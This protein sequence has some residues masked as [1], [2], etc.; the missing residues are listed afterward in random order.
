MVYDFI[1]VSKIVDFR[2][3]VGY[4][5]MLSMTSDYIINPWFIYLLGLIPH[6]SA[7]CLMITFTLFTLGVIHHIEGRGPFDVI[8]DFI[9]K[10][11]CIYI[12]TISFLVLTFTLMPSKNTLI[13]M[14][15]A[16]TVT[17]QD[18]VMAKEEIV[19]IITEISQ[20]IG[21]RK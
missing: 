18:A 8:D 12:A 16:S 1:E 3:L 11:C 19:K 20:A 2:G 14:Y 10:H 5:R 15:I 17:K 21:G 4:W 9:S 13:Q 7:L 6:L